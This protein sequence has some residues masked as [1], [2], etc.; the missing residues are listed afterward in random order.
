MKMLRIVSCF[1]ALTLAA[2]L[3]AG[4]ALAGQGAAAKSTA[5][6]AAPASSADLVDL[7]SATKAQLMALPG[8]GDAYADKIAKGRPYKTKTDLLNK[9]IVPAST[10]AKIKSLVIAKQ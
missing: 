3:P 7:N 5:K 2:I 10:Y 6:T 1:L 4:P 9:S 8:I